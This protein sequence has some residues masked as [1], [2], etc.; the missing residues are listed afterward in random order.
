MIHLEKKNEFG[1]LSHILH[2]EINFKQRPNCKRQNNKTLI[3]KVEE[4]LYDLKV[5]F[6][7][8]DSKDFLIKIQRSA[9]YI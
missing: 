5:G 4:Y 8:Q 9:N 1:S 7:H 2:K 3:K 6:P